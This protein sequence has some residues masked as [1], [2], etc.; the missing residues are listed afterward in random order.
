MRKATHEIAEG[1]YDISLPTQK[2]DEFDDL[3]MDF[4]KMA[5]SLQKSEQEIERQENLKTSIN[6]GCSS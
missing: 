2:R 5:E 6:D 3:V 1:N 4:N